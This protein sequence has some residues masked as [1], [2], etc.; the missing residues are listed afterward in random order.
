MTR[1]RMRGWRELIV[2][3]AAL[4]CAGTWA[5]GQVRSIRDRSEVAKMTEQMKTI[6]VGRYLVD[7]PGEA[8]TSLSGEMISGFTIDTVEESD[9]QFRERVTTRETAIAA[10]GKDAN[11]ASA[12]GLIEVRDL[13]IAGMMGRT[14]IYGRD[15]TYGFERGRRVDVEWVSVE[16]HAHLEGVSFTLSKKV[17]ND[18]DARLA[19]ALLTRLRVRGN[20]DI[21]P[22]P[23]FCVW[24][25]I[26]A[27]P[28]PEHTNEHVVFHLG[29]PGH[30]D[31]GLALSSVAGGRID[32]GLLERVAVADAEA[33]ADEM[34]RVAKLRSGKRNINGIEGE[35]VLERVRELNFTTGYSLMWEARGGVD[36][37]LQPHLL[38]NMETGTNPRPGG[39]PVDSSLHEDAVLALWDSISSSIRLR[40]SGPPPSADP[41]PEPSGP[42]LGALATAGE[43]CPQ[44][45]WWKCREGGPG[46]DVQGGSV[47]WIR[48]GDRMPQ[49]LLL[50][51]QT[52]WQKL[53]GLQPSI[54]PSQPTT[55]RLVDKRLRPRTPTLVA[56]A[57]PGPVSV[58]AE[59]GAGPAPAVGLGTSVR[60]GEVC[61]ASG[62]WRCGET[63]AL[64][65]TRW[66]PRGSTLPAAT[67]QVSVG[68]FGRSA[69][70]EVIQRRSTW[71]LMRLAEAERVALFAG[72]VQEGQ[73]EAGPPPM[74]PS[75]LA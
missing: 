22:Y 38:L 29:L 34:L 10:Q 54:E 60:T 46:V 69:G 35:E 39:K 9:T 53:R 27:E 67:F 4:A 25:G 24:R 8:E 57:P 68:M 30:P 5:A 47:Q 21:P 70:P 6:C 74:G 2:L 12:G 65:G 36:D 31:M 62:W 37:L 59:D 63:H 73:P 55:W 75:T 15:R 11:T 71:Q 19:E 56:L 51:R 49:A 45:G 18:G 33:S 23:G 26:F 66:F 13:R 32:D 50:P 7:V 3:F 44:S 58:A 61:P 72:P 20:D 43:T 42:K 64:D 14:L 16:V 52:L 40:K 1:T 41:P 28:L 48:K 17:A